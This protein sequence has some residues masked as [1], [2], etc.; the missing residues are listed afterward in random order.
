[1]RH[2]ATIAQQTKL[3]DFLQ[4]KVEEVEGRKKSL[5]DKIFGSHQSNKENR[6]EGQVQCCCQITPRFRACFNS[7]IHRES[8]IK[9]TII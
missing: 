9:K 1:M 6:A 5:A 7:P 8:L 4:Q 2:E 3:I